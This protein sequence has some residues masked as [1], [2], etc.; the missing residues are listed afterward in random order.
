MIC[1]AIIGSGKRKIR[2]V[3]GAEGVGESQISTDLQVW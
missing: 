1:V 3:T 2:T